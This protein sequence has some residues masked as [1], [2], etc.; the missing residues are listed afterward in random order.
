MYNAATALGQLRAS[1][2]VPVHKLLT[3]GYVVVAITS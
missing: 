2:S 1:K 3:R